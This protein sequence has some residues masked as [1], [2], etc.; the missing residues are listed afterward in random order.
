MRLIIEIPDKVLEPVKDN[1]PPERV[2]EA[3]ALNAVVDFL[4]KLEQEE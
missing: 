1:L 3:V 4:L 2:L